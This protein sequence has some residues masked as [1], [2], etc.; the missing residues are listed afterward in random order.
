MAHFKKFNNNYDKLSIVTEQ[1][2]G[3]WQL[4]GRKYSGKPKGLASMVSISGGRSSTESSSMSDSTQGSR[5]RHAQTTGTAQQWGLGKTA[6]LSHR[7]AKPGKG[8]KNSPSTTEM[9]QQLTVLTVL[10]EVLSSIPSTHMVA[11]NHL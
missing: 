3:E 10:T 7:M 5:A 1:E 11:Y 6:M 2:T 9:A 4:H 8:V